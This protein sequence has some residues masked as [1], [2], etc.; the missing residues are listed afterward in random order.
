MDWNEPSWRQ[1]YV[2][3]DA[4][5]PYWCLQKFQRKQANKHVSGHL[6]AGGFCRHWNRWDRRIFTGMGECLRCHKRNEYEPK[7]SP[8]VMVITECGEHPCNS[9]IWV[10]E[11]GKAGVFKSWG[12]LWWDP[13]SKQQVREQTRKQIT[14]QKAN[15]EKTDTGLFHFIMFNFARKTLVVKAATLNLWADPFTGVSCRISCISDM[16]LRFLTV[17]KLQL[18][19]SNSF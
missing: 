11:T 8:K 3:K 14:K 16:T 6:N 12:S 5:L 1:R 4:M 15:W 19:S 7:S 2:W 13:I 18:W 9:S 17:A 10:V